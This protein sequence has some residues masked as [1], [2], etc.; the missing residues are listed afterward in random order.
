MIEDRVLEC[1][2]Q[3]YTQ[4]LPAADS[5]TPDSAYLELS[6][7]LGEE[8]L[9]KVI[10]DTHLIYNFV[11]HWFVAHV[12]VSPFYL[13]VYFCSSVFLFCLFLFIQIQF[14]FLFGLIA[15]LFDVLQN[16]CLLY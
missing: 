5:S 11:F 3:N 8:Q 16:L 7:V 15:F 9:Q 10:V 6:E 13:F 1:Y 12:H 14:V 2:G 4:G